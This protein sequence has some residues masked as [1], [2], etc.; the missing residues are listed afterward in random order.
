MSATKNDCSVS[1]TAS[2]ITQRAE[3]HRSNATAFRM[4]SIASGRTSKVTKQMEKN[5][6]DARKLAKIQS[7]MF[8]TVVFYNILHQQAKF[9]PT[10]A[11]QNAK[12]FPTC[13]MMYEVF[14]HV[15]ARAKEVWNTLDYESKYGPINDTSIEIALMVG[16]VHR[17]VEEDSLKM[18]TVEDALETFAVSLG[19]TDVKN[20]TVPLCAIIRVQLA[21]DP[22]PPKK[23]RRKAE[24]Y[25]ESDDDDVEEISAPTRT[26]SSISKRGTTS[27]LTSK[28][29]PAPR[30][31]PSTTSKF[32]SVFANSSAML[33]TFSRTEYVTRKSFTKLTPVCTID[34]S[35]LNHNIEVGN[36]EVVV[37]VKHGPNGVEPEEKKE[38]YYKGCYKGF[39]DGK[40]V[41]IGFAEGREGLNY[42]SEEN[43]E[44]LVQEAKALAFGKLMSSLFLKR[45]HDAGEK[46]PYKF[47]FNDAFVAD[48]GGDIPEPICYFRETTKVLPRRYSLISP[49]LPN[50]PEDFVKFC[51]AQCDFNEVL[52]G[53]RYKHN[54]TEDTYKG[55]NTILQAFVHYVYAESGCRA[56]FADIQGAW[57]CDQATFIIA[58]PQIHTMTSDNQNPAERWAVW[59]SGDEGVSSF[60]KHHKCGKLCRVLGLNELKFRSGSGHEEKGARHAGIHGIMNENNLSPYRRKT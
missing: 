1:A 25:V 44:L 16:K 46:V 26:V 51:G 52:F 30:N 39:V 28:K 38:G 22:D 42:T 29:A 7:V 20:V 33:S 49:C 13:T 8:S 11:L 57:S 27:R 40:A 9:N 21:D 36:K 50:W 2:H 23:R 32:T 37:V 54:I 19:W 18:N 56:V 14:A 34:E 58:D 6:L 4:P 12:R 47:T 3:F 5:R 45:L 31:Q 53:D 43:Y 59:D 55:L 15:R 48:F 41:V 24:K 35:E 17:Q 60:F 10:M